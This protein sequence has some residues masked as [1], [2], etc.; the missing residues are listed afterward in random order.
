MLFLCDFPY[1]GCRIKLASTL[2]FLA[3]G[4]Y[5]DICFEFGIAPGSFYL[6]SSVLW[7]T[8]EALDSILNIGFPFQRENE[9]QKTAKGF[10]KYSHGRLQHCVM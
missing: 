3:G 8:I 10:A 7:G 4:S 5:I 2:R 6:D 9:L 1:I